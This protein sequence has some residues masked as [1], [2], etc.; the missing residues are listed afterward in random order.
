MDINEDILIDNKHKGDDVA[1]FTSSWMNSVLMSVMS[2]CAGHVGNDY[3]ILIDNGTIE[4][5][6]NI[7]MDDGIYRGYLNRSIPNMVSKDM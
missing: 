2:R 4:F 1:A 7:I 5:L 6:R 3:K